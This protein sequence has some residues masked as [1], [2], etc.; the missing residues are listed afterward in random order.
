MTLSDNSLASGTYEVLRRRLR[1]AAEDMRQR[2]DQLNQLRAAVFGNIETRLQATA[3]VTTDHNCVPRDLMTVG[4]NILL[5]FNVQFGLKTEIVPSDV[6]GYYHFDSVHTRQ[7]A[8]SAI[9]DDRFHRDFSELYRYYRGTRF[10]RFYQRGPNVHMVFQVGK[11]PWDIKTFKWLADGQSLRYIDNRSESEVRIGEQHGFVWTR[12]TRDNHRQGLHPHI[13]IEDKVFV[14][15]VGG[16]LTIKVEDNTQ[17]GLGIYREPVDNADQTLDD[18]EIYYAVLGDLV[19]LKMRPYQERDFRYLVFSAKKSEVWRLDT[20]GQSCI[21]LPDDHGIIFP[22]GFCLQTGECKR[23]DHGLA[24]LIYERTVPAPNG[25]DF[26]YLFFQPESGTYVQLRYNII[27][28][29]V[30]TPWICHG[31][32]FLE[33]GRMLSM[34]VTDTAQKHHSIQVWQ[35]PFTGPDFRPKIQSD[36]ELYKIGN[37]ELVR[38]MAECQEVLHL[39]DKDESYVGL[40]SDLVKRTTDLLD[41]YFWLSNE[42]AFSLADP[43]KKIREAAEAAVDEFEKVVRAKRETADALAKVA[44]ETNDLLKHIDRSRFEGI[45]EFVDKLTR[46]RSQRGAAIQ[47]R[48]RRYIDTDSVS[49]METQLAESAERLGQRCVLFLLDE[50]SLITYHQQIAHTSQAITT[51]ESVVQGKQIDEQFAKIASGLELLIDTVSQ[52]K[53]DDLTQRTAIIDRIGELLAQLNKQRSTLKARLRDISTLEME[54]DYASQMK[55][56]DQASTGAMESADSPEAI[57]T[58]LTRILIQ[59]ED[60]E[61]R[62]SESET[63]LLRLTEKRQSICDAFEAKREYWLEQRTRRANALVQ[64]ADR[65]LSGIASR[66]HRIS[67]PQALAAFFAADPMVD[68]V[69]RIGDQLRELGDTVRMEDVLSRLKT[70]SDDAVRLQRDRSELLSEGDQVIQLGRHRFAVNQQ[71]AELTM[72]VRHDQWNLHITGTQ[73]FASVAAPELDQARDMW[74]QSLISE[75][76]NVYRAEYLAYTLHAELQ[77]NVNQLQVYRQASPESRTQWVR[78][79]MQQR[80]AEGYSR[81]VHDS[82]GA[83]I[84]FSLLEMENELGLLAYASPIRSRVWFIWNFLI[85]ENEREVTVRW[86]QSLSLVDQVF[87]QTKASESSL[88]RLERLLRKYG[89]PPCKLEEIAVAAKYL[90]DQIRQCNDLIQK[91]DHTS[92]TWVVDPLAQTH[93]NILSAGLLAQSKIQQAFQNALSEPKQ[94][95]QLSKELAKAYL[96]ELRQSQSSP[97]TEDVVTP[98]LP[99]SSQAT[100]IHPEELARCLIEQFASSHE[101]QKTTHTRTQTQQAFR[102]KTLEGIAG[103]HARIGQGKLLIDFHDFEDRLSQYAS[104]VVPRFQALQAA[105]QKLLDESAKKLRTHEFKARVLTSFVRNQL[106]D[107]VY[108]PRIGD[109][110]AKQI[111][112]AGDNKRTDRMGLLLLISPPGYGK[113]TLM[114]YIANRLGL[115]LVKVN[116]P[117]LGHNVTSLDPA[118]AQNA[119]AREEV[120]RI[121]LALEMGDNVML[122]LDDIQ[123]CNS[124]LLQKFI[125]LCDATRRIE[126]V[127]NDQPKTYDLRGRRMAV[128]MAG[129]PY[130]ESGQR[131]HIPDMLANRADIYNLGEIIGD[132][133]EAFE[134]SYLENCLTSNAV[135]QPLARASSQDQRAVIDAA[136][137]GTTEGLSVEG[138]YSPDQL[139]EMLSVLAKLHRVRDLVLIMNREYI[140]SAAQGDEYRTEPPFKLQGSYRNMNRIAEKVVP[141]MN[142]EELETLV[143]SSY[144]QD[145]QT[146]S[147]DGESN[148]L[149]FRELLGKQ[150][151][152]EKKRWEDIKYTFAERLRLK[153][154]GSEDSTAQVL[155]SLLGLRDGL[156]SIRRGL[157]DATEVA[158]QAR[159]AE[160]TPLPEQKILVQHSVPRVMTE[161]IRSQ[162]QLLYDGLRPVLEQSSRQAN[163]NE[164]LK[165]AID[166]CLS[167]YRALEAEANAAEQTS[168]EET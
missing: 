156:E 147:R 18:A 162:F 74:G 8:L 161:L 73:F 95:W 20:I 87:S 92:M 24:D 56:L 99:G 137:R 150:T 61:S 77:K 58:A 159:S 78:E 164:R 124:E 30:D 12:A 93:A 148:M 168:D 88:N 41:G 152:T 102:Q 120:Q 67:E 163:T 22:N 105:K 55:L 42:D 53:I 111:G 118:E 146:L 131:F 126:G 36:S 13:S 153:G 136:R 32:S 9:L 16:D 71:P 46:I 64:A 33:D 54:A 129:N 127:W 97:S 52:L 49:A 140:R 38:G 80:Y 43:I 103:D 143:V 37:R 7:E 112:A 157:A 14:E 155:S 63:L 128:V 86:I 25:E 116:G 40:Y 26:L 122:Y 98:T 50:K 1:D 35:T 69:R 82:D 106:I 21:L 158:R 133:R 166:D 165:A 51:I 62:Y 15:C 96:A 28:R 89:K 100:A 134:L 83:L 19:V 76:E 138:N 75:S 130:T 5:G 101:S 72:V 45:E 85:P 27:R 66:S 48:E 10:S 154:L 65:I 125:P 39:I 135:L 68:K 110:L 6:L 151:D 160:D 81:G 60:L 142:D 108:L 107:Q 70:I 115:V 119:S 141:V 144:E 121:N 29:E 84:L 114:E 23:F 139:Q 145:S 90:L 3:H 44:N 123:H 167:R 57:D 79:Q 17:D 59:L 109:N 4:H 149:K 34:R 94:L 132:S 91:L 31:Q 104:H 2:F 113:T 11:G 117:A 47:L